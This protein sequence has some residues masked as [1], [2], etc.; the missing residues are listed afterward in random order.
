M[1]IIFYQIIIME[2][3][4]I[5]GEKLDKKEEKVVNWNDANKIILVLILFVYFNKLTS[6][7]YNMI[8][9]GLKF[10]VLLVIIKTVFKDSEIFT[11]IKNIL[12]KIVN[13]FVNIIN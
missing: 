13:F 1:E 5:E 7:S 10:I 4:I 11:I 8:K 2:T 3:F 9:Y 12:E 6:D